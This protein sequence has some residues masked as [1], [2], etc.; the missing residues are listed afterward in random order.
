METEAFKP[1][2]AASCFRSSGTCGVWTWTKRWRLSTPCR[3]GPWHSHSAGRVPSRECLS[4]SAWCILLPASAP[5]CRFL[6]RNGGR[7]SSRPS[8]RKNASTGHPRDLEEESNK[9]IW[10][11]INRQTIKYKLCIKLAYLHLEKHKPKKSMF[12]YQCLILFLNCRSTAK[13]SHVLLIKP[14]I[15]TADWF[16]IIIISICLNMFF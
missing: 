8:N 12:T 1:T 13:N 9:N 6:S 11:V 7:S 16:Y 10:A 4:S 15:S 3:R 2:T 5:V 14:K